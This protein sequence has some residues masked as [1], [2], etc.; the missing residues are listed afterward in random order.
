M[1]RE[2]APAQ[3]PPASPGAA[4]R[5]RDDDVFLRLAPAANDAPPGC[6]WRGWCGGGVGA[7]AAGADAAGDA[8]LV[9]AAAGAAV[10][11]FDTRCRSPV[12]TLWSSGAVGAVPAA[13]GAAGEVAVTALAL[14]AANRLY[15]AAGDK[16]RGWEA[17]NRRLLE[18]P[19]YDGVQALA[20]SGASLFSASR[21]SSLKRWSLTENTLTHFLRSL[22]IR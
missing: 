14:A 12:G 9:L 5:T 4:R 17:S 8:R 18:P 20:L 21:D 6:A 7:L 3:T 22:L 16:L 2:G 11:V 15:T 19:H 10:R 13:R 1:A